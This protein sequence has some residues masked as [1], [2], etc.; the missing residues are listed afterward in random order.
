MG[1]LYVTDL[2]GT[3]LKNDAT[4][5]SFSR[6]GIISILEN[7]SSEFTVASARGLNSIK[8]VLGEIHFKL[9]IVENNGAY[10]TD[11]ET[12]EHLQINNIDPEICRN[13]VHIVEKG[14]LSPYISSTCNSGDKLYY[15]NILNQGMELLRL[16]KIEQKDKRLTKIDDFESVLRE[17]KIVAFTV[18][19][20]EK[21][22]DPIVKEI[23]ELYG[24]KLN[25]NYEEDQYYPGWHWFI[26]ND[27]FATKAKA[28]E[29]L[30]EKYCSNCE[31]L[32]VFGDNTNDLPMFKIGDV[33]VAVSNAKEL[34]KKVATCVIGS[35]EEDSVVK[36]ILDYIKTYE[37]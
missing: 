33:A 14:G 34:V 6:N 22:L 28:I 2:D 4:L 18:I 35:N 25:Y 8:Y 31:E 36:Y 17:D 5:S 29:I 9:P 3:L 21:D 27:F 12:G 1:K 23:K 19:G 32:I 30:R 7:D 20:K 24:E 37:K 11:Y 26:I 16:T 15:K 13:I 10:I